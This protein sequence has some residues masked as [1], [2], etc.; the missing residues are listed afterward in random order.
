MTEIVTVT[1]RLHGERTFHLVE[2]QP[3]G[4]WMGPKPLSGVGRRRFKLDRVARSARDLL[5][6]VRQPKV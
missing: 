4:G 5:N 6:I 2:M 3:Y 1:S